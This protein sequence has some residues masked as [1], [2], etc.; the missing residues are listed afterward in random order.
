[1]YYAPD[2]L[3]YWIEVIGIL[4]AVYI[5]L[6]LSWKI[7]SIVSLYITNGDSNID[8]NKYGTWSVVTGSTDGIGLQFAE[9][10]AAKGQ[11]IVLISRSLEK[12]ERVAR[13]I[14]EKYGVSTKVIVADYSRSDIY[15]RITAGLE[16]L[17]IGT[18]VN[19][20][21]VAYTHPDNFVDISK[22]WPGSAENMVMVN[23]MSVV[24]MTEIVLPKMIARKKGLILNISSGSALKPLPRLALYAASKACVDSF[25]KA[26]TFECAPHGV[27][28]QS[29]TPFVVATKLSKFSKTS[30]TVVSTERYV[31]DCLRTVGRTNRTFGCLPH[32]LQ[33]EAL[34]ALSENVVMRLMNGQFKKMKARVLREMKGRVGGQKLNY[35]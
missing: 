9:Q 8:F 15:D 26:L 34:M 22:A 7:W 31:R 11:N 32:A 17:T 19:N 18:L 14:E 21:G 1:M 3:A 35:M 28:V 4:S 16:G 6:T 2:L 33:G 29:V 25:S 24:K 30:L 20:V 5:I 27:T 13:S 12:L 10:L 23:I